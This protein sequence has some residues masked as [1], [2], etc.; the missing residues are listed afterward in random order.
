MK[1]FVSGIILSYVRIKGMKDGYSAKGEEA[2]KIA[3]KAVAISFFVALI[4]Y[5]G[6]VL[7]Q[8]Y[9]EIETKNLLVAG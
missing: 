7:V 1:F 2:R 4:F 8:H 5:L 9:V 6:I 3:H